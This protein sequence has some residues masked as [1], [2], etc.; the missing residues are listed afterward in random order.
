MPFLSQRKTRSYK[1]KNP[2]SA[3]G[4]L[5]LPLAALVAIGILVVGVRLFFLPGHPTPDPTEDPVA[6]VSVTPE[7]R[8]TPTPLAEPTLSA[9]SPI[10]TVAKK[11]IPRTSAT[12]IPQAGPEDPEPSRKP[13]TP[14]SKL[15]PSPAPTRTAEVPRVPRITGAPRPTAGRTKVSGTPTPPPAPSSGTGAFLVQVGAFSTRDAAASLAEK[16]TQEGLKPLIQEASV[17]TSTFFRVRVPGGKDRPSAEALAAS[18]NS[19]GYPTQIVL[20]RGKP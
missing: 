5:A 6:S 18:L 12:G 20:V 11:R 10:P 2:L 9:P 1:R 8:P 19:K 15:H 4:Q 16:L 17:G 3:F 7:E 13:R 14:G